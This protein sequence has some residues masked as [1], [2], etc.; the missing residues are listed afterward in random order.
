MNILKSILNWITGAA[1]KVASALKIGKDIGNII[2][3]AI[4]SP[5]AEAFVK[6]T[7]T[8]L[9]DAALAYIKPRITGWLEEIGWAEIKLSDLTEKTFPYVMNSIAAEVAVLK[10]EHDQIELSRQ[11]AIA[12]IQVVYNPD[13]VK[14]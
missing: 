9:D 11:Q 12:S 3:L 2:K 10:A 14:V 1:K 4:D 5:L 7:K 6:M 13:I 8:P